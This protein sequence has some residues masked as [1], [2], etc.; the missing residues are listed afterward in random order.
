[1]WISAAADLDHS[2]KMSYTKST[3]G[4]VQRMNLMDQKVLG[5]SWDIAADE[6]ATLTKS[7]K[8]KVTRIAGKF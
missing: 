7:T 5:V 3:L 2:D 4:A 1:M 6:I 8:M